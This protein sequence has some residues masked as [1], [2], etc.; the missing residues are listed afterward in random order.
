[1]SGARALV[2]LAAPLLAAA[3]ASGCGIG[4]VVVD[5]GQLPDRPMAERITGLPVVVGQG[6]SQ[7]GPYRAWVYRDGDGM[8]CFEVATLGS[9]S[10][11][12]GPD[13]DAVLGAVLNQAG[14]GWLVAGGTRAPA[15]VAVLH[16]QSGA[17]IRGPVTLAP[18]GVT[19]GIRYYVVGIAGD[20]PDRLELLDGSG[21]VV[22]TPDI[23]F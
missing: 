10:S 20:A 7:A 1:M 15:T 8:L 13:E 2:R 9:A 4:S 22:E 14:D 3:V 23:A 6:D 19:D 12:C 18:P 21:A 16:G 5:R 11:G 17:V